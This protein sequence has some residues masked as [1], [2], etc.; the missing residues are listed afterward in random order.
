VV[1]Q[2]AQELIIG[3]E[4]VA[5]G[6]RRRLSLPVAM[7]HTHTPVEMPVEVIRGR[8]PGPRLFITAAVHGD[9]LNGIEIIRRLG[10][11]AVLKRIRG[12]LILVPV[13]NVFGVLNHSRYLP[14]RRDLNRSFPG[15]ER[16]SLAARLANLV[17]T[18][19]IAGSTHGIDLHTG[20]LHRSNLPQIR[21]AMEVEE[22][23]TMAQAFGVP[24]ILDSHP[25][26]GSLRASAMEAGIPTVV[27]EAGEALQFDEMSIRVGVTGIVNVMRSIGMLAARS[28]TSTPRRRP[29][30]A[31]SSTWI[32]A[33]GGGILRSALQL[34]ALVEPGDLLGTISDPLGD[35]EFT[36]VSGEK[37]V[38]VGISSLPLVNEG[39]AL[40]HIARFAA[41]ERVADAVEE[42][43][44]D[45][46]ENPDPE[47]A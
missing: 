21:G 16:G 26:E 35:T 22:I 28:G 41:P 7:L 9:E 31:R 47:P 24:A 36:V 20:A 43:E 32:R 38:V 15:S 33:S 11:M 12:T 4:P 44:R 10:A 25:R 18:E 17:T 37:G 29:V 13:V 34:G 39:D 27:Y 45:T 6:Q 3:G 1:D 2:R 19:I 23:R 5:A 14:D 8:R 46:F 42:L 40:F 30:V